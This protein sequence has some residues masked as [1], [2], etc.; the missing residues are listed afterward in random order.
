MGIP[1]AEAPE[2][3]SRSSADQAGRIKPTRCP[4]MFRSQRSFA[5][6]AFDA[7]FMVTLQFAAK[8]VPAASGQ[9]SCYSSLGLRSG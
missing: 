4:L 6:F 3:I 9:P 7:F 8:T 2:N 1:G 5:V